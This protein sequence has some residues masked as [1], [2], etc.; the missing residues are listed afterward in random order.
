M[1]YFFI[2]ST[3]V[4]AKRASSRRCDTIDEALRGATFMLSNGAASAWI[5]D[6]RGNMILPADEVRQRL[7]SPVADPAG[8]SV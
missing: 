5:V 3:A 6:G 2:S 1:S 7:N 8:S 4:P